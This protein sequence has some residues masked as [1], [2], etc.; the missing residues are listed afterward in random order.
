MAKVCFTFLVYTISLSLWTGH[1][2]NTLQQQKKKHLINKRKER[3]RKN[4]FNI[5][6]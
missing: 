6:L 3:Q 4:S 5:D 2:N 1:G